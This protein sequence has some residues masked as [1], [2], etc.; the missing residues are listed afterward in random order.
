MPAASLSSSTETTATSGRSPHQLGQRVDQRGHPARVVRAVDD[1]QRVVGRRPACGRAPAP[2]PRPRRT[3]RRVELARGTP[4]RRPRASAKLRRWKRAR[5][6]P[7]GTPGSAGAN[8]SRAPR[9]AAARA[10]ASTSGCERRRTPASPPVAH[11]GELLAR[12][13][14]DRRPEPARVLEPDVGEHLHRATAMHVGGVVAAAEAGLDHGDLDAAAGQLGERGGGERL[15]LRHAV[16][17]LERAVD[18]GRGRVRRALHGG[19][20][21]VRVEVV[22]R[23]SRMRSANVD[24]VRRQVGAG[25]QRR[26]AR[27]SPRSCARSR[28]CRSCPTTWIGVEARAAGC[29]STVIS[30]RMRSRPN[31]MPNSSRPSR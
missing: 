24:Q 6:R 12:D 29:P 1:R 26:G 20:E 9:S 4:R 16:V 18:L 10:S 21:R 14:G 23:R 17:G 30:R 28:T 27:G 31:R 25:A 5:Q 3:A 13:V 7:T 22:R 19:G 15:E 8:T 11:D 2:R